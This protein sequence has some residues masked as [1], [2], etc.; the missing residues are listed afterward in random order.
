M[1]TR[2]AAWETE[3]IGVLDDAAGAEDRVEMWVVEFNGRS[4]SESLPEEEAW[5][6]AIISS[7][8]LSPADPTNLGT[9]WACLSKIK[10]L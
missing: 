4:S 1:E 7:P 5:R 8:S 3:L 10:Q 9:E 2:V 6:A